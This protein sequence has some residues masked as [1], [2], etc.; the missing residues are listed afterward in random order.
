LIEERQII[1]KDGIVIMECGKDEEK[2]QNIGS[3]SLKKR[4]DYGQISVLIYTSKAEV[5]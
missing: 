5:V 4:Y 1:R 3:L 2:P